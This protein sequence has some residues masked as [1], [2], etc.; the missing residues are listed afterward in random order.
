M[1]FEEWTVC[2]LGDIV[3]V[4]QG[5]AINSKSK[6]LL[7]NTGLPLLRITDLFNNVQI[8]F[9]NPKKVPKQFIANEDELIYTRTGQVGYVF[10]GRTGVVH[11]N[12][13]K[14]FPKSDNLDKNFLYWFL[15]QKSIREYANLIAS[16]SVQKDLTHSAFKS[17]EISVPPLPTQHRIV[18]ILSS[19]DNKIELNRQTNATLEAIAQ[20]IFKEWFVNFNFPG[21]TGEMIESELG[22][23][24]KGWRVGKLEEIITNYDRKRVPLSS[25]ER[26][27][28]KGI[29]PYFGAASIL[30]YVDDYIFD[31]IYLL[32]GE[33]GTVITE[34]GKP[35][36]QY[37]SG[38][39]WVNNHTH[40]L[41]GRSPFSTEYV[42]LQLKNTNVKHIVTGAVQ[43]KINQ[44]N[45]NELPVIIPD[46]FPLLS[47]QEIINPIFNNILDTEQETSILT[48]IRDDLLPKFMNGEINISN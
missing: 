1:S 42:L 24:P 41:Q 4:S 44:G 9:I 27:N 28:R 3:D 45:M 10:K 20:A 12:C 35:V 22:M 7:Q 43:P 38:K 16:G 23:I 6:Y 19:L 25:R 48:K 30:D 32:M 33:D 5:L 13:F 11:N 2:K 31:G 15:Y 47:F 36:L 29:F 17:I 37:V 18:E 26:E 40:V 46:E 34:N 39:F 21:A 14:V 8:Q